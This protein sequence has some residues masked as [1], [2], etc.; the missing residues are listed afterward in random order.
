[1]LLAK[2]FAVQTCTTSIF[3]GRWAL[4]I[5]Q[6]LW[7]RFLP[8]PTAG[9]LWSRLCYCYNTACFLWSVML[10]GG[11]EN[12]SLKQMLSV[13]LAVNVDSVN[14]V[15]VGQCKATVL[16]ITSKAMVLVYANQ[17]VRLHS[18]STFHTLMCGWLPS[19][20]GWAFVY[21]HQNSV[22]I[23]IQD[24]VAVIVVNFKS[25]EILKIK[26]KVHYR[27]SHCFC[28]YFGSKARR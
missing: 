19:L 20:P 25:A 28:L 7:W 18:W 15:K 5:Q 26:V 23:H 14:R 27:W 22:I 3:A 10:E 11:R 9:M 1:M 4:K 21:H 6:H 12:I 2:I 24:S 17:L 8:Y 13:L 16:N